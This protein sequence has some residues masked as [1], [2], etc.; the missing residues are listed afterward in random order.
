LVGIVIV[1]V[2]VGAI[3]ALYFAVPDISKHGSTTTTGTI[4]PRLLYLT[5]SPY[6]SSFPVL[7]NTDAK[8]TIFQFGDF[9]C[10]T[11]DGWFKNEEPSVLSDLIYTGKAKLVWRDYIFI[12]PDSTNASR[13]AYAAGNQGKF[14]QYYDLL[15]ANQGVENSGWASSSNLIGFARSLGLNMAEFNQ[16]YTSGKFDALINYNKEAAASLGIS[17]SPTFFVVGPYNQIEEI[18]GPQPESVFQ[19]AVTQMTS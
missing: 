15:Y 7:G 17:S 4:D 1:I 11:C 6:Y 19:T 14:W 16:S 5:L 9:Q 3:A 13:A 10:P 18:A 12:G 2:I 8:V